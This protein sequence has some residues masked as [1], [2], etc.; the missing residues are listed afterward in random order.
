MMQE[1]TSKKS[2]V[3]LIKVSQSCATKSLRSKGFGQDQIT[4]DEQEPLPFS[5]G[6][7][8]LIIFQIQK[9][10]FAKAK[11]SKGPQNDN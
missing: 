8:V 10:M 7:D 2:D 6:D 9:V 11:N 1:C 3:K 5:D 4:V